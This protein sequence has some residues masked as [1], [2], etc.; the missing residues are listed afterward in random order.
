[1][2]GWGVGRTYCRALQHVDNPRDGPGEILTDFEIPKPQNIPSVFAKLPIDAPIS[3]DIL[4]N[5][6]V[7][8]LTRTA[9][10]V[11]GGM[12]M[13]EGTIHENRNSARRPSDVWATG[14]PLVI[15]AP[16]PDAASVQRPSQLNL[17][18]GVPAFDGR[19]DA[20]P[21]LRSSSVSHRAIYVA[22]ASRR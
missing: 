1:M 17:R 7:P 20:R 3:F 16:T 13:P 12:T 9:G 15:A 19:H 10:L 6:S 8:I 2:W 21:L 18:T 5:L 4:L 11:S 22:E 14:C